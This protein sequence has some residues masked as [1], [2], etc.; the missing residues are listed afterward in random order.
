MRLLAKCSVANGALGFI[1]IAPF[2][3]HEELRIAALHDLKVLDTKPEA[4]FDRITR[5]AA[6]LYD[7][8]IALV[9]LVDS[10]RQWFKACVGLH[11]SQTHRDEAFCAHTILQLR[12]LV[13]PNALE[14][15]RFANYPN[16]IGE[17]GIRFYAGAPLISSDGYALGSMCVIDTKPRTG[18]PIDTRPLEDLAATVVQLLEDRQRSEEFKLAQSA[19]WSAEHNY[20]SIVA[21]LR[22]I[23]FRLDEAGRWSFLNA[24]WTQATGFSVLRTLGTSWVESVCPVDQDRA[25]SLWERCATGAG[26]IKETLR[27][28]TRNG[29]ILWLEISADSFTDKHHQFLGVTGTFYDL[30]EVKRNQAASLQAKTEA[31][32]SATTLQEL[33]R[34]A[35]QIESRLQAQ[36]ERFDLTLDAVNQPFLAFN[37]DGQIIQCNRAAEQFLGSKRQQLIGRPVASA[38]SYEPENE[39]EIGFA[40]SGVSVVTGVPIGLSAI[41]ESGEKKSVE[42]TVWPFDVDGTLVY[43]AL[44]NVVSDKHLADMQASRRQD[45]LSLLQRITAFA[46][47]SRSAEECARLCLDQLCIYGNFDFG[48][49]FVA[50]EIATELGFGDLSCDTHRQG[51]GLPQ[52]L[53]QSISLELGIGGSSKAPN[54]AEPLWFDSFKASNGVELSDNARCGCAFAV[55]G[56]GQ[57]YGVFAFFSRATLPR[58]EQ[59]MEWVP[60]IAI[61]LG[62][63]ISRKL[64]ENSLRREKQTAENAS[65]AKSAFVAAMSH[66]IRTPMNA[67]LGMADVLADT[68][69]NAEQSNYV[70]VFQRAGTNL[71]ALLNGI[72]DLSKIEAGHLELEQVDFDLHDVAERTLEIIRPRL[73]SPNVNL[74]SRISIDGPS[75]RV[76]DPTRLQQILVNLLGNAAKFTETGSV[77]LTVTQGSTAEM[78]VMEVA[79]TG[80]GIPSSK[81]PDIFKDFTQVDAS[82]TRKY[83]G[84]G[85]G[86]GIAKR[87]VEMMDG[88]IEV[89]SEPQKGTKFIFTARLPA[90]TTTL[91]AVNDGHASADAPNRQARHV[92]QKRLLIAD[93]SLDNQLL[94][95][96][97][98]KNSEHL[99]TYAADG[100]EAL[101][102]FKKLDFDL[103]LMDMQM[104]VM[105]GLE[106]TRAIRLYEANL[107]R[108]PTPILA[109][110][111]NAMTSDVRASHEAGADGHLTKPISKSKFLA[112]IEEYSHVPEPP[113]PREEKVH[114]TITEGLE[115]LAPDYLERRKIE[116]TQLTQ[117][118]ADAEFDQI[119][120]IAHNIT[121]SGGSFGFSDLTTIGSQMENAAKSGDIHRLALKI[122]EM[123]RYLSSVEFA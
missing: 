85:L 116:V 120:K 65:H 22:Q 26:H 28:D 119:R 25:R 79:D 41:A 12:T 96:A 106:V 21:G 69:L 82:T 118:L 61:Q 8:P 109:F 34:D 60:K 113:H 59:L 76:G 68:P 115:Q 73:K 114:V 37:Q 24:A 23:V 32:E 48:H 50:P 98:L 110:T 99:V 112:A 40:E 91:A 78:L 57:T 56:S 94:L 16:V 17:P 20:E 46:N 102:L 88:S 36:Y 117:L 75:T 101:D 49:Y 67:I 72:L 83:G 18:V 123:Q 11:G 81:L 84:T 43:Q 108:T 47:Q 80:I 6:S 33:A 86:L 38:I 13:I 35:K 1:V 111:A 3:L 55:S 90:S 52:E 103:V 93:D 71:L 66:E 27:F 2:P 15:P 95:K 74:S 121:G 87:L 107:R 51:S 14:D 105:D 104:P 4:S 77:S 10:E 30:T 89:F 45:L 39:T 9:S 31:A 63:I 64:L 7:V 70:K 122:G 44:L 5:I 42:T 54:D 100:A 62:H 53:L 29:S 92:G 97:Y 58:D 19:R